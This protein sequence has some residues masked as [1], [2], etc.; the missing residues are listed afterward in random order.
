MSHGGR[1]DLV[2]DTLRLV[3]EKLEHQEREIRR[4]KRESAEQAGQI[5]MLSA[6]LKRQQHEIDTINEELHPRFYPRTSGVQVRAL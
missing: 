1:L 6:Q 2:E 4:L 5:I 3:V